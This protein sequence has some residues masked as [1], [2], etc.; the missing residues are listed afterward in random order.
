MLALQFSYW[1][2]SG[3]DCRADV[4]G[5]HL[6]EATQRALEEYVRDN[7]KITTTDEES[8]PA[9]SVKFISSTQVSVT[10]SRHKSLSQEEGIAASGDVMIL[11]VQAP[12]AIMNQNNHG[13]SP[14]EY[15]HDQHRTVLNELIKRTNRIL[16]DKND[17]GLYIT[18]EAC[19]Y[20]NSDSKLHAERSCTQLVYQYL[21]PLRWLPDGL[22]LEQW[23]LD[24]SQQEDEQQHNIRASRRLPPDS[25]IRVLK[26]A[27]RTAESTSTQLLPPNHPNDGNIINNDSGEGWS[28]IKVASGRF[29]A[30]GSKV[31]RPWHNY[32]D[33]NLKG[34]AS[35]NNEPVWRVLDRARMVRFLKHR[36]RGENH[37]SNDNDDYE[38]L[39]SLEF[40]GDAFLRE[41]LRRIVGTAVAVAHG[42]LPADVFDLSTTSASVMETPIAPEGR[43]YLEEAR[44]HFDE[45]RSDGKSLFQS[46][47]MGVSVRRTSEESFSY[48]SDR[49]AMQLIQERHK[50]RTDEAAWLKDLQMNV[51][52]RIRAQLAAQWKAQNEVTNAAADVVVPT[53]Y[54]HVLNQLRTILANKTWPETSAARSSVITSSNFILEK[55]Q[56]QQSSSSSETNDEPKYFQHGS[57]TV[58][59]PL[60][61]DGVYKNGIG[62]DSP[63]PLGNT[64]F[65]E[66]VQAVFQLELDL[67]GEGDDVSNN[68]SRPASS[69]CA[70]NANAQF[71][72][73]VDSGRGAGQSLSMIVGMGNYNGG[74]LAVEGEFHDIQYK[75]LEFDG[76][77]LRHW[78]N[79]FVGE[80][81][82]LVWFT[83]ESKKSA[84]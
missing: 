12:A 45:L 66:L 30:L 56:E 61:Q 63:L 55:Q 39:A 74:E 79:P 40:R 80:R 82:S 42:W 78:T 10:K 14:L 25:S 17:G 13:V 64:L 46:D 67:A 68:R 37:D 54:V 62:M 7:L 52:P 24:H 22:A 38:V 69:H 83:P 27:L 65:P 23:W 8:Q 36:T 35:P 34:D 59:N 50:N 44:F 75:P 77:K 53:P 76:W 3:S 26:S 51:A 43:L 58:V 48:V 73:H 11:S 47:A 16:K 33:P 60:F 32:A 19:K 70:I 18:L 4:A 15:D 81:F 2:R 49:V 20:L 5:M 84:V 29:G 6:A 28:T 72:P 41:Q 31:R 57:F 1:G 9:S 71:S 21:L